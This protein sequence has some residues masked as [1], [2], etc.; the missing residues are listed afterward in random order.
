MDKKDKEKL[1]EEIRN[2]DVV[3]GDH[4]ILQCSS[5]E[6]DL[7]DIWITKPD[8]NIKMKMV[9][10]CGLCGDKSFSKIIKGSFHLGVTD[11]MSITECESLDG[12]EDVIQGKVSTSYLIHTTSIGK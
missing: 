11:S 12:D 7:V 6:E 9:A 4:V 10:S 3:N 5:C 2:S 8:V 1:K